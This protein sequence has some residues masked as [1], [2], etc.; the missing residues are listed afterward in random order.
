M[1]KETAN[2]K[3]LQYYSHILQN[4]RFNIKRTKL[5]VNDLTYK[6]VNDWDNK[7]LLS[8]KR[9]NLEA[10]WRKFSIIEV[11]KL[12]I[13]SDLRDFGL[14]VERINNIFGNI[15]FYSNEKLSAYLKSITLS[16]IQPDTLEFYFIE[17]LVGNIFYLV[18]NEKDEISFM[19]KKELIER[20]IN[21]NQISSPII[22]LPFS[23]YVKKIAKKIQLEINYDQDDKVYYLLKILP[24][25]RKVLDILIYIMQKKS[26]QCSRTPIKSVHKVFTKCS[27]NG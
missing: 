12:M 14:N 23:S 24:Q 17:C 26:S 9:I 22:L 8:V 3:F 1:D 25:E 20:F 19:N 5:F 27:Q 6:K 10:G 21:S 16:E 15:Y 11:L 13:I 2:L 4:G 18:I 7:G